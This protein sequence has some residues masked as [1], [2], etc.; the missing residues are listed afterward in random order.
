MSNYL[1]ALKCNS[2]EVETGGNL[3]LCTVLGEGPHLYTFSLEDALQAHAHGVLITS[4]LF[5][6]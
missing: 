6:K 3:T 4:V 5:C 2:K 1:R